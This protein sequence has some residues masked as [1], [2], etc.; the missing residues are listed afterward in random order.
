MSVGRLVVLGA[1]NID[2]VVRGAR[3][4]AP[5]E[6]VVGGA[7]ERHHG[8]KG[9]NQAVAAARALRGT[10][11]EGRVTFLGAVGDDA[12]GADALAALEA[13]RVDVSATKIARG[14]PTG[15]ALIVV[16]AV[17]ENQIAVAPGANAELTA[18]DVDAV[19]EG[20]GPGSL[21]LASLEVPFAS[22]A[23]AAERSRERGI[24]F[25]L[26]P[27]PASAAA[28]EIL[29][30]ASV[31]IPNEGELETIAPGASGASLA[32]THPGLSVVVT[33]GRHGADVSGPGGAASIA[34]APVE[35]V[36]TT[37]AGDCLN[38][39][40]AAGRFEGRT[41]EESV[42][43]AVAAAGLSVAVPGAREGM[44]LRDRID[45]IPA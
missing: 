14:I 3:L 13:E 42:R 35:A 4:P 9:A 20:L 25:F 37:G 43:R 1:A 39:V 24:P 15:V 40:F 27:A 34:A 22:I 16:D 19:I 5:G 11:L 30:S 28:A 7:F 41:V 44:P 33:K 26:N 17:G 2:L 29:S 8:G 10:P 45:R 36:D 23:R 32:A 31:V 18:A 21:L 6:T 12:F 38:G